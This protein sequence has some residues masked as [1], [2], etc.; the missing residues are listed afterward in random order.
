MNIPDYKNVIW[1][2][3]SFSGSTNDCV[4]VALLPGGGRVVRDSKDPMGPTLEFTPTEWTAFIEGTRTG[5]F[6]E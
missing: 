6:G 1:V 3:S 4:E 2:K 5:E